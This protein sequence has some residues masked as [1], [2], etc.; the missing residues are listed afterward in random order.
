[1]Q[2]SVFL[3]DWDKNLGSQMRFG[4]LLFNKLLKYMND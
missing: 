3:M 1:M 4:K 2:I